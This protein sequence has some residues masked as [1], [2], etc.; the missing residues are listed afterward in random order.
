MEELELDYS[1]LQETVERLLPKEFPFS[2]EAF[3]KQFATGEG[4]QDF[5]AELFRWLLKNITFPVEQG[6]RLLFLVLFSAFFSNLSKAFQKNGASQMGYL[7]IYL[8]IALHITGGFQASVSIV[9]EGIETICGLASVLFPTYCISIAFVTGSLTATGYYQGTAFFITMFEYVAA[10]VLLPL[11]RVYLLLSLASCMQK[12]PIFSK[13]LTI[14]E[15]VFSWLKKTIVG[16][17]LAF[18]AIQGILLPA[19][20]NLKKSAIIKTASTIPGV[21]NLVDGA[22]E[23]VVGAGV[24]LKNAIGIGG[25]CLLF[26]LGVLPLANLTMQY[27][28]YRVIGALAEP[29]LQDQTEQLLSYA[30][31][32]QKL[33]LQTMS[34]GMI[35]FLMLLVVMT[36]I[37]V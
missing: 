14:L 4:L 32:A 36:R 13:L 24:V 17:V 33:L 34:L 20:D 27:L 28:L 37:T 23:T 16:I 31:T 5:W 8:L 21:G 6:V 18:S 7:C 15:N 2:A 30:G 35:L 11:S 19:I 22:W 9:K 3:F 12:E 26:L 29:V 1:Q 25:V 10:I